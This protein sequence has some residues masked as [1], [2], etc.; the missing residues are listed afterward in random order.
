VGRKPNVLTA[1]SAD[2]QS[3]HANSATERSRPPS[4]TSF[5]VNYSKV[6]CH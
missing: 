2:F 1:V 4:H 3:L 6:F 5:P